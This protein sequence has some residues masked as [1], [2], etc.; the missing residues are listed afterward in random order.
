MS[1][2][3]TF[4]LD[5]GVLSVRDAFFEVER[6]VLLDVGERL[7]PRARRRDVIVERYLRGLL[8]AGYEFSIVYKLY[9]HKS[10]T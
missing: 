8:H 2:V 5:V 10:V 4:D 1:P 3:P 9:R 7:E 6:V